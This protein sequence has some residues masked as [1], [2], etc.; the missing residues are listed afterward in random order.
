MYSRQ[1]QI[2]QEKS[3]AQGFA[4]PLFSGKKHCH[5]FFL[6]YIFVRFYFWK[7]AL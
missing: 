3:A 7:F 1:K 2:P 6:C 4:A 5:I